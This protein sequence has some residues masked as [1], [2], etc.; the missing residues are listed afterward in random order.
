MVANRCYTF[1]KASPAKA[2]GMLAS[3]A[4]DSM[5]GTVDQALALVGKI[6]VARVLVDD[7]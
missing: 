6:G 3:S 4:G 2:E 7:L 5:I 1:E